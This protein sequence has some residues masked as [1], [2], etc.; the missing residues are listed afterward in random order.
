MTEKSRR[1]VVDSRPIKHKAWK[2]TTLEI[3]TTIKSKINT[4]ALHILSVCVMI[5]KCEKR[6]DLKSVTETVKIV[7]IIIQDNNFIT[8]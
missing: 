8:L 1:Q 5:H 7:T 2:T 6:D 3:Y 4:T